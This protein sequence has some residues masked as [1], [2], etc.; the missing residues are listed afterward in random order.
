M[1]KSS[2]ISLTDKFDLAIGRQLLNGSQAIARLLLMQRAKD[3][4]AGLNT[5]GYVSGYRGSPIAGLEGQLQ[6]LETLLE[7]H[8]IKFKSGLNEDLAATAVWG[9][10]QVGL[11]PK[12]QQ[13]IELREHGV[14]PDYVRELRELGL[15]G[16]R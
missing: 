5:A 15:I 9:S 1:A 14:K 4:A 16:G 10:Q 11:Y 12:D 3:Q 2:K 7:E 8:H 13:L 6:R